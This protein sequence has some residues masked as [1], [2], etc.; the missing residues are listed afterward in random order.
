[1][2]T[3]PFP[4]R[5]PA[6][7]AQAELMVMFCSLIAAAWSWAADVWELVSEASFQMTR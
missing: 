6:T 5:N 2:T 4:W 7:S 1:M 3:F